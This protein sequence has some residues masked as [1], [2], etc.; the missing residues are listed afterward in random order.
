MGLIGL[1]FHVQRF[2]CDSLC[3]LWSVVLGVWCTT[4]LVCLCG[5]GFIISLGLGGRLDFFACRFVFS[6]GSLSCCSVHV[7]H[8]F[9]MSAQTSRE[10]FC[11]PHDDVGPC[12]GVEVV[13]PSEWEDLLLP[14]TDNNSDHTP[15]MCVVSSS[16]HVNVPPHVVC[17]VI[18]KHGGPL[19]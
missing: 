1:P 7:G 6:V 18:Q 19:L 4:S 14:H 13:F 3:R 2:P 12:D 5:C 11:S 16:P 9:V 15:I 10:D 8:G 17:T